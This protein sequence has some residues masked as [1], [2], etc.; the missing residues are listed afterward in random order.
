MEAKIKH[1]EFIQSII[2]RLSNNAFVLKGWTITICAGLMVLSESSAFKFSFLAVFLL[3]IFWALDGYYLSLER[4]YRALYNDIRILQESDFNMD[5]S[6][7]TGFKFNI[8][9]CMI[10]TGI[11]VF[12]GSTIILLCLYLE[13]RVLA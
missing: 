12:H 2:S 6:G 8:L 7:Y 1:L 13:I 4:R 3:I 10:S 9:K 11:L 5:I